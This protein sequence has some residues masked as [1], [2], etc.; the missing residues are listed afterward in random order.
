MFDVSDRFLHQLAADRRAS[1]Q[2]SREHRPDGPLR[3]AIG[4]ALVRLGLR[5]RH[6]VA[7]TGPQPGPDA[8]PPTTAGGSPSLATSRRDAD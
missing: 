6:N 7:P 1:L 3:R 5:L 4:S 8:G 2:R